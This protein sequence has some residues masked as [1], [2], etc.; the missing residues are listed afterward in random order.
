MPP[1]PVPQNMPMLDTPHLLI[2]YAACADS[3]C[4]QALKNLNLPHLDGLL[5]RLTLQHHDRVPDENLAM[6]HERVLARTAGLPL[7]E[8]EEN[9]AWAAWHAY[10]HGIA[11]SIS[12]I[13]IGRTAWAF[14]TPCHWQ[15]GTDHI[16]LHDPAGLHLTEPDSRA[17]LEILAPWFEGDGITLA[18]DQ[19]TRWLAQGDSLAH[20]PT[21]SLERVCGH[22]VRDWMQHQGPS[23]DP[24]S[25][26]V[27]AV[28][29]LQRL[30]SE[31]QM[32][33]Y[34]HPFNDAREAQGLM[35][36]NAFWLHGAGQLETAPQAQSP[37][38]K[39]IDTLRAPAQQEDWNAWAEAW[40]LL[41]AGPLAQLQAHVAG[42]GAAYL[43][44]AGEQ[45]AITWHTAPRGLPQKI[46]SVFR[47]QR[48][49]SIRRQL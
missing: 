45:S 8:G 20:L 1:F 42:G 24:L 21:P 4:Q 31:L 10:Q 14:V 29:T 47:P 12:P 17:L 9:I 38:P 27:K 41:D 34:T 28:Q 46:M 15:V 49:T 3:G 36:I 32:L 6:P 16:T 26:H 5:A 43:T 37:L 23:K 25:A 19:P 13:E 39:V 44:L 22:D 33:L 40:A 48:F 18:Y 35:P 2:S 7:P 30:H 11:H